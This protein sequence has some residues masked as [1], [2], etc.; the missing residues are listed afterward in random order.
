MAIYANI[1][2]FAPFTSIICLHLALL[3][4]M[5]LSTATALVTL[6]LFNF[7]S[8]IAYSREI[9]I[10]APPQLAASSYLLIDANSNRVLAEKNVDQSL[11]PASITKLMASYLVSSELDRGSINLDDAVNISV[12]AWK[13]GGSK[14]FIREGTQVP[15]IDLMRGMIIQ[16]GNDA[17]IALAEHVAGSED[18]FVDMMNQRAAL[19]GMTNTRYLNTTGWPEDGHYSSARDIALLTQALI[20]EFPENY[21]LY[22]E[23]YFSYNGINQPN[24]NKLLVRD[25]SVDGVK[26]GHTE[27]AGYCLVASAQKNGMRLISVVMG[28]RSDEARQ[29]ETQKLLAYGFRYYHTHKL[30]E[31]NAVVS[32]SKIWK[33]ATDELTL[34]VA[35]DTY[36]TIPRGAEDQLKAI[37][38]VD[39]T[40]EAPVTPGQELGNIVVTLGDEELLSVPLVA[41]SAVEEA[42]F[43]VRL[44]DS[45]ALFF[46]QL[47]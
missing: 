29:M 13:K 17:T 8:L 26:T 37:A 22:S 9:I 23:Q 43:F 10:P 42:G 18:A 36:L 4:L 7:L 32:R 39:Q 45:V 25:E 27:Q 5:P 44:R 31:K 30:Y 15:L 20:S 19:L 14:M 16:S 28:T 1:N 12:K 46:N 24:R 21:K 40:I 2:R 6:I 34:G 47:F 41:L 11:P 3:P 38:N 33:G 35:K